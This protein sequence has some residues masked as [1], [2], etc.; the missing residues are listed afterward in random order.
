MSGERTD[1]LRWVHAA[2]LGDLSD[3]EPIGVVVE[4]I[5]V[6]VFRDA[7]RIFALSDICT[8]GA[9]RLSEGYVEDGC[10]ECPLHQALFDLAT[11]EVRTGPAVE[12][13][14]SFEVRLDG[15][16]IMVGL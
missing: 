16:A 1:T 6:A 13:V 4:G 7:D 8:H 15:D 14:R 5:Q 3:D 9:A 12:P 2:Q 10:V 11:G